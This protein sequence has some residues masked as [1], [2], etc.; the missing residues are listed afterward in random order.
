MVSLVPSTTEALHALGAESII[1]G[2]SNQ[3]DY[4]EAA[5]RVAKVGDFV[6]PD[7]ERIVS[8]KPE[9]VFLTLPLHSVIAEK[10]AELGISY[11]NCSPRSVEEMFNEIESIAV[12]LGRAERGRALVDSLRNCLPS[13]ISFEETLSVYAE[14]SAAPLMTVGGCSYLND[15]IRRSGG[16]NVFAS[17]NRDYFCVSPEE[18]VARDPGVILVLHPASSSDDVCRRLGWSSVKAVRNG[19]V[20]ADLNEDLLLRP[21]PRLVEGILLLYSLLHPES[22]NMR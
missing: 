13:L 7:L 11:M 18:V 5:R 8:L 22:R 16:V 9:L 6:R 17:V 4:P 19:C 20:F 21:G 1:V 3:C 15:I 2:N 14:I 12:L 10:L